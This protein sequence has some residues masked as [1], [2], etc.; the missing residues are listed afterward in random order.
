MKN[1]EENGKKP[2][3]ISKLYAFYSKK[4]PQPFPYKILKRQLT[5]YQKQKRVMRPKILFNQMKDATKKGEVIFSDGKIFTIKTSPHF[6]IK[7]CGFLP[8]LT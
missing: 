7:K 3:N 5:N 2:R 4:R 8:F 1:N 6:G